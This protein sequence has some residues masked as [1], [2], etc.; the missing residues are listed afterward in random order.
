MNYFEIYSCLVCQISAFVFIFGVMII[1][2]G[3]SYPI[4][5]VGRVF[6]GLGVGVGFAVSAVFS[7]YDLI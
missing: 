6:V 4:L 1:A 7:H 3:T 5:M 2:L